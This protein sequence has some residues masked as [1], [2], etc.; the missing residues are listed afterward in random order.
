[1]SQISL[2]IYFL[3]YHDAWKNKSSFIFLNKEVKIASFYHIITIKK[4]ELEIFKGKEDY[5]IV[6]FKL[7]LNDKEE[8]EAKFSFY[9]GK[10]IMYCYS[11][12]NYKKK[13]YEF[14]FHNLNN[15]EKVSNIKIGND[16][17][18]L[19]DNS[20]N[21]FSMKRFIVINPKE[22]NIEVLN[23]KISLNEYAE[24][25][26][27]NSIQM[28]FFSIKK[29]IIV[30][31]EIVQEEYESIIDLIKPKKLFFNN[32]FSIS[33]ELLNEYN[34]YEKEFK[35]IN[36]NLLQKFNNKKNDD[37]K[38]EINIIS[39][40]SRGEDE[41]ND[42]IYERKETK[43]DKLRENFLKRIK[44]ILE[45]IEKEHLA[46]NDYNQKSNINEF[47]LS[48]YIYK[49]LKYS[50]I[51]PNKK[52]KKEFS[53]DEDLELFFHYLIWH[54]YYC[55]YYVS[56][57]KDINQFAQFIN[58]MN[59]KKEE[60]FSDKKLQNYQK[61]KLLRFYSNGLEKHSKGMKRYLDTIIG[62]YFFQDMDKNSIIL[63]ALNVINYIS[64]N[65]TEKSDLF[66]PLL[67]INSGLGYYKN[68]ENKKEK[69]YCFKAL[70]P[71]MISKHLEELTPD[72]FVLYS[73]S[74]E[75]IY[76]ETE[77]CHGIL[78]INIAH[79][80]KNISEDSVNLLFTQM[81]NAPTFLDSTDLSNTV[82]LFIH[83][84]YGHNKLIYEK[85]TF[86][87]SPRKFFNKASDYIEMVSIHSNDVGN[88]F[89]KCLTDLDINFNK[90]DSGQVI[91]Y[92]FGDCHFGKITRILPLCLKTDGLFEKQNLNYW[93]DNLQ[94]IR[95]YVEYKFIGTLMEKHGWYTMKTNFDN[96][97]E[98]IRELRQAIKKEEINV[99]NLI[100][101]YF[102]NCK[103]PE[104]KNVTDDEIFTILE[105]LTSETQKGMVPIFDYWSYV[106]GMLT[107]KCK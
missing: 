56:S 72:I 24:D 94:F 70:S 77:K 98:E 106:E 7:K 107:L 93:V 31:Q 9:Y 47:G 28:S 18:D 22:D 73:N 96:L 57:N 95:K 48:T 43:L 63:K 2:E 52:I 78:S 100:K 66:F 87:T 34:Q 5:I 30:T 68:N 13:S 80:Y 45:R 21:D 51:I 27:E 75:D 14:I 29:K 105:Y 90:G 99:D 86:L 83:E 69:T 39:N 61:A 6:S 81:E 101:N 50:L 97:E 82:I 62:Y 54:Y 20:D 79:M 44:P 103:L 84:I 26:N 92:F 4:D 32:I 19:G 42:N 58:Y 15:D 33:Q 25:Y 71:K 67:L 10:N 36:S 55:K 12:K 11:K 64:A 102:N 46:I 35:K 76:G 16:I 41:Q 38:K 40:V 60:I 53:E 65:I 89:Y 1:M 17:L 49:L 74:E 85:N 37:N 104:K 91:E 8:Y 23:Q 3:D 59:K 88:K